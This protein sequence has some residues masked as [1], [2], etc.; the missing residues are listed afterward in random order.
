MLSICGISFAEE[1]VF[2]KMDFIVWKTDVPQSM[3]SKKGSLVCDTN[4]VSVACAFD[5]D[6]MK[7]SVS[8]A[9]E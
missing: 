5:A 1:P 2:Q 3:D 9:F 4:I 7:S 8:T 6:L